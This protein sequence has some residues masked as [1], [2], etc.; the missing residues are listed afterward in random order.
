[1]NYL[2]NDKVTREFIGIFKSHDD[3]ELYYLKN[4]L[5]ERLKIHRHL[6]MSSEN[7]LENIFTL[8]RLEN[9]IIELSEFDET[10]CENITTKINYFKTLS[11]M[12]IK[13]D[14]SIEHIE[15]GTFKAIEY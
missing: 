12:Y 4:N 5:F 3:A 2:I 1:M 9:L 15:A 6:F 13:L 7:C 11:N 14:Y 10:E 8:R